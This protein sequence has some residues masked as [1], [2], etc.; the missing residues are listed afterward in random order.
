MK[1]IHSSLI[2]FSFFLLDRLNLIIDTIFLHTFLKSLV[3][4]LDGV[5]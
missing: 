3:L 4:G 2:F 1:F 5:N